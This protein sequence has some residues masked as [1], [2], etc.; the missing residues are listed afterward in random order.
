MQSRVIYELA[1]LTGTLRSDFKAKTDDHWQIF[2]KSDKKVASLVGRA[3]L[4][5]PNASVSIQ[6]NSSGILDQIPITTHLLQ[7][8]K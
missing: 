5:T 3:T 2:E 1:S 6:R 4:E 7:N 8:R